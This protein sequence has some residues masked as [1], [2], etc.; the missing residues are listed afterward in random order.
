MLHHFQRSAAL[1]ENGDSNDGLLLRSSSEC[2]EDWVV[3]SNSY[4]I[5]T[6][7]ERR[8]TRYPMEKLWITRERTKLFSLSM[9]KRT[10]HYLAGRDL[11]STIGKASISGKKTTESNAPDLLFEVAML[12]LH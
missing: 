8:L 9:L 5:K 1:T 12:V 10:T 3:N 2:I 6:N 4:D 11:W 7:N